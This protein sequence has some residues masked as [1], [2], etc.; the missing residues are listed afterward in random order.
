[1]RHHQCLPII[2]QNIILYCNKN[3]HG[4]CSHSRNPFVQIT[5]QKAPLDAY[6]FLLSL[7]RIYLCLGMKLKL[8]YFSI[9]NFFSLGKYISTNC[10]RISCEARWPFSTNGNLFSKN[11]LLV[12][13]VRGGGVSCL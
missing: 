6:A 7:F 13:L 2:E 9:L 8:K 5:T 3:T 4:T 11:S 12:Y 10:T 1:M